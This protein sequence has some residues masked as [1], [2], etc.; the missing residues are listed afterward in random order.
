MGKLRVH[1]KEKDVKMEKK[2]QKKAWHTKKEKQL[3]L[4][5]EIHHFVSPI[6]Q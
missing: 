3:S 6:M 1:A 2:E 5:A 4:T